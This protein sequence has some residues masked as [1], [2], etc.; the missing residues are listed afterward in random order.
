MGQSKSKKNSSSSSSEVVT[1]V[2]EYSL[3]VVSAQ[4]GLIAELVVSATSVDRAEAFFNEQGVVSVR[5]DR[6]MGLITIIVKDYV[7]FVIPEVIY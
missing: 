3:C 4:K 2:R 7:R 6:E 5:S 1:G